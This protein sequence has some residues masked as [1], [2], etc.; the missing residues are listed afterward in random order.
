MKRFY[1]ILLL[2]L[3][4]VACIN[5]Q[6]TSDSPDRLGIP[7]IPGLDGRI[8]KAA[9]AD[10]DILI[11]PI[12]DGLTPEQMVE[13]ILGTGVNISN[14]TYTGFNGS[15]GVFTNG[16]S[17][18]IEFESGIILS[19]GLAQSILGPNNVG[20]A[21]NS[22]GLPGDY[23]LDVII[24]GTTYDASV[25]EFDF[26]PTT[27]VLTFNYVLFSEEYPEY[28]N[29]SDVF[30]FILD[31]QNIALIP[32][33][34]E[35]VAI[36]TVN[37][38]RYADFYVSNANSI[39]NVQADGFTTVFTASALVAKNTTH[40]IKLAIADM[41]D[42]AYDS[43]VL[44]EGNSFSSLGSIVGTV[45][46]NQ[47]N[48]PIEDA[49]VT[50]LGK[51]P[52]ESTTN[53]NGDYHILNLP[54]GYGYELSAVAPDYEKVSI[55]DIDILQGDPITQLNIYLDPVAGDY[56]I[57][58][59]SP[60]PN[61]A[62]ST[63]M[64]N[65][66]MLHRYYYIN[67]KEDNSPGASIPVSVLVGSVERIYTSNDD[68]IV[69][70]AIPE[71]L[72]PD[73]VGDLLNCQIFEVLNIAL[74][75]PID[76]QIQ[77]V[78]AE[79]NKY[80]GEQNTVEAGF[81]NFHGGISSNSVTRL[82]ENQSSN[83]EPEQLD[84][85]LGKNAHFGIGASAGVEAIIKI[86]NFNAGASAKAGVK[87][88]VG[89]DGEKGYKFDYISQTE[90]ESLAKYYF[91]SKGNFELFDHSLIRL[92]T[93]VE[94]FLIE[95]YLVDEF[96]DFEKGGIVVR[97]TG[98]ASAEL[99]LP[100]E[101]PLWL[102]ASA[103]VDALVSINKGIIIDENYSSSQYNGFIVG[104]GGSA[105]S[106]MM[107]ALPKSKFTQD[108]EA[109]LSFFDQSVSGDWQRGFSLILNEDC[110]ELALVK[111]NV[112]ND[113]GWQSVEKYTITGEDVLYYFSG[114]DIIGSLVEYFEGQTPTEVIIYNTSY[115]GAVA[116]MFQILATLTSELASGDLMVE[117]ETTR[118]DFTSEEELNLYIGF[119]IEALAK[120]SA[121]LGG[122]KTL[123]M[124]RSKLVEQGEW[125]N[126][127]HFPQ[128]EYNTSIPN[129]DIEYDDLV[130]GMIDD[131]PAYIRALYGIY[132]VVKFINFPLKSTNDLVVMD[133]GGGSSLEIDTEVVPAGTDSIYC[134][135][136]GWYGD[137]GTTK[138]S[139][140]KSTGYDLYERTRKAAQELY[141]MEYGVGG[142]FQFEP[143]E[144]ELQGTAKLTISYHDEEL[145][146]MDES[147]LAIYLED[148]VNQE[149]EYVGGTVDVQNNTVTSP[150]S[151]M[152][153]YTL[154]P[155]IP[156]GEII[157]SVEQEIIPADGESTTLITTDPMYY[158]NLSL[159]E[160]GELYTVQVS[161]GIL[162]NQDL[163]PEAE[164][165]Q[166]A[167]Q[168]GVVQVEL[169]S[170]DIGAN[171]K[172]SI[173]SFTGYAEGRSEVLFLDETPP[174]A[175]ILLNAEGVNGSIVVDWEEVLNEDLA[176]YK[177]YFDPDSEYPP[178]NGL[179][180]IQG[181]PSPI[182][183][184]IETFTTI[185]H[186]F[187]D[188]TYHVTVTAF[189][190][191]G[192]ES[193]YSNVLTTSMAT[194]S[195]PVIL[196]E[197]LSFQNICN[198]ESQ[199]GLIEATDA[200]GD[201]LT[202]SIEG[203]KN[204]SF[205]EIDESSGLIFMKTGRVMYEAEQTLIVKVT[206]SGPGALSTSS[207]VTV[208]TDCDENHPPS[209]DDA[210][211]VLKEGD[212][213]NNF[214]VGKVEAY[215][216]DGGQTLSYFLASQDEDKGFAVHE[217]NG[218]IYIAVDSD[219]L[220][221]DYGE[222][223]LHVVAMD[224][225]EGWLTDTSRVL[226]R[227]SPTSNRSANSNPELVVYP[228]PTQGKVY[229]SSSEFGSEPVSI[230]VYSVV[231]DQLLESRKDVL[232]NDRFEIDLSTYET[233]IYIIRIEEG[234]KCYT[235]YIIKQ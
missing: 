211:F 139:A 94:D 107:V 166:V 103:E 167:S 117:Y 222:C 153:V 56:E 40:H 177:V 64:P 181:S 11:T 77:I 2:V 202:F 203:G 159:I 220:F 180:K 74:D 124:G 122:G 195:N 232:F 45:Y 196:T 44:I 194:N 178:Y 23:D 30:A 140:K 133:L 12:S 214:V 134:Y 213:A 144:L 190:F 72:I 184:G 21:S 130:E 29:Y 18:G 69:D 163:D 114:I 149:W 49:V 31:G 217:G 66:K 132:K 201:A 218:E 164:G 43:W 54:F 82:R 83:T 15:S 156:D 147:K 51:S 174:A 76:F 115:I 87:A 7:G 61:P 14:I 228:N 143:N 1:S 113:A 123:E 199:V 198:N 84:L 25:L 171:S 112:H 62:I 129:I 42:H 189:D 135:S 75:N 34:T 182:I 131:I 73:G 88:D 71:F 223:V 235:S 36:G 175:P 168:S 197:Q 91:Y 146:G 32:G 85:T 154:A 39:Y 227:F 108:L 126:F 47:T 17:T 109:K 59:M 209:I 78:D 10:A 172:I 110:L 193:A 233:G 206:D 37:H 221:D 101:P 142:F 119:G 210:S 127:K 165:V 97:G 118:S 169:Q 48:L 128:V 26:I 65:A 24:G 155:A 27:E 125:L 145:E 170:L 5:A 53:V 226:I 192:N 98:S 86:N 41:S 187:E 90:K 16:R 152:A 33:T 3:L 93:V 60:D 102:S 35:P 92:G 219:L 58:S 120:I 173:S 104:A 148:K 70:V 200:E 106:D 150:I 234:Q 13:T 28:L 52:F 188:S 186:L 20:N 55:A 158:N 63:A 185:P 46:D 138:S 208:L 225:G 179:A 96:M 99:G 22:T 212:V 38:T 79:Y 191:S 136:W 50:A 67:N 151:K 230:G 89:V 4:T 229:I 105:S 160:D 9:Q 205:F 207:L 176:G 111:R 162:L 215:E 224:N 204:A 216:S 6:N 19:S 81:L 95:N 116:Q 68:G 161:H 8:K 57:T 141:K 100:L 183:L 121:S 80:W 137:A 157:I 231:G